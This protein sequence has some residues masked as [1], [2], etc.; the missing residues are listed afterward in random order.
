MD[1][2]SF[3]EFFQG[4]SLNFLLRAIRV[5]LEE[6]GL[7]LTSRA[8]FPAG[9]R[10]K[11]ALIAKQDAIL[12]GLS[13]V[14]IVMAEAQRFELAAKNPAISRI[15]PDPSARSVPLVR[16]EP[17]ERSAQSGPIASNQEPDWPAWP[18]WSW[19]PVA[20]E[21]AAVKNGDRL[22]II[23]G[24][25]RL[26]LK[27]ERIMLNFITHMSG[28]ATLTARYVQ[29]LEG[30]GVRLLDTR[31]TLP[32]LRAAEKYAV[33]VGGGCNHRFSLEDMLML[34]DNHIDAAGSISKAVGLLRAAYA[35]CPPIEVEC[36]NQ[37]EVLEAVA[38]GADRIMLD[39]MEPE[40]IGEAMSVIPRSIETE[41]S[42]GVN[43]ENI[44]ALVRGPWV[45]GSGQSA[46]GSERGVSCS[47]QA[48]RRPPDFISVGRITHSA[49][50]VDFSIRF[51]K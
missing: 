36:R 30:S 5:A 11:I 22:A 38:A 10:S 31:K 14:P 8:V 45:N 1:S 24:S 43:L 2:L 19:Q 18:D 6:D 4:Q 39:N 29:A 37:A 40:A 25:T 50:Q 34:K 32:G 9:H 7:E 47:G 12:A 26:L 35:P 27:A 33:Q 51:L 21:G 16:P 15:S 41:V 48:L 13:L 46:S 17:G 23:E 3:N 28:V 49:P 20:T 44:A 42:G